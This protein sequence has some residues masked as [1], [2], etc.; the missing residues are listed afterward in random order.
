MPQY[1]DVMPLQYGIYVYR[2]WTADDIC[3]YVGKTRNALR[4]A[5]AHAL[6]AWWSSVHYVDVAIMDNEDAAAAEEIIQ[7]R[8]LL[9]VHNTCHNRTWARG[10]AKPAPVQCPRGHPYDAGN[11]LYNSSGSRVCRTCKNAKARAKNPPKGRPLGERNPASKLTPA[12]VA[13]IRRQRALGISISSL[14]SINGVTR[15]TIR[16]IAEGRTWVHLRDE[17]DAA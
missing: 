3:V 17:N 6:S 1:S 7:I 10:S 4:R 2:C 5:G 12:A 9:P 16:S 15:T 11:T 13:E 14:A 8:Q